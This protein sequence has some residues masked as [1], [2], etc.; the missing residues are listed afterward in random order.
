MHMYIQLKY[1]LTAEFYTRQKGDEDSDERGFVSQQDS[2][3]T[4]IG[5]VYT[6]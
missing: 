3:K 2:L 4:L 6:C 5:G 1:Y